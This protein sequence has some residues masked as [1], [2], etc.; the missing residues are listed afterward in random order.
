MGSI[1]LDEF[2]YVVRKVENIVSEDLFNKADT[3]ND[4]VLDID[5]FY[6]LVATTP[7]LRNN[8]DTIIRSAT[9]E[10]KRKE[11]ER[12]SRLFKNDISGR[13]PDDIC[14]FDVPL[15]EISLPDSVSQTIRRRF[16]H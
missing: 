16:G 14:S 3:N 4:G 8:F 13:R 7:E 1:D 15:Y 9:Q 11:F 12:R 6:R 5:E 2:K 10:N